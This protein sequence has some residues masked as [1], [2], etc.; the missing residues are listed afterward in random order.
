MLVLG[1]VGGAWSQPMHATRLTEDEQRSHFGL[2]VLL[3]APLLLGGDL[4]ALERRF[5]AIVGNPEVPAVH[6]DRLGRQAT[7]VSVD[8]YVKTWRKDLSEGAVAVG[9]FNRGDTPVTTG[10]EWAE[11][12][13]ATPVVARDLWGRRE[14]D[15]T[16]GWQAVLPRHGCAMLLLAPRTPARAGHV[17]R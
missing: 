15:A 8:G 3:T 13:L 6:Q 10:I 9:V 5:A 4:V 12:G 2:W 7:R 14:L 1:R 16:M 17:A 11:L